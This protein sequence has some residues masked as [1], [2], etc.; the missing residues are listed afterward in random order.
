AEQ[1]AELVD[2]ALGDRAGGDHGPDGPRRRELLDHLLDAGD[3]G[4][5]R[6]AV[7]ADHFVSGGTDPLPH[8][9]AHPA[10][11]DKAELHG[12]PLSVWSSAQYQRVTRIGMIR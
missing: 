9:A 1:L 2:G 7:V 11:T 4:D 12:V 3:V 8:V 5:L 6:V 10:E